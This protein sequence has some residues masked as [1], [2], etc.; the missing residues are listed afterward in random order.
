MGR[1]SRW[2]FLLFAMALTSAWLTASPA[3]AT[4]PG[5]NG[6]IAFTGD[7]NGVAHIFTINPDGS[8][9]TDLGIGSDPAWSADG[10]RIVFQRAGHVYVMSAT[11][12]N[13]TNL[14]R[15]RTGDQQPTW[16][17][18]GRRIAFIHKGHVWVML[19]DGSNAH[20]IESNVVKDYRPT[21]STATESSYGR[22]II[23][24]ARCCWHGLGTGGSFG[25][26][27]GMDPSGAHH[28]DLFGF[29]L[30]SQARGPCGVGFRHPDW[31]PGG[32]GWFAFTQN[33]NGGAEIG[34]GAIDGPDRVFSGQ[35]QGVDGRTRNGDPNYSPDSSQV[36]YV[37]PWCGKAFPTTSVIHILTTPCPPSECVDRILT[38]GWAPAWQ[39]IPAS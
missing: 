17:P 18:N 10:T 19:A 30:Q 11:G 24:V 15:R 9:R 32:S 29:G 34:Y 22:P 14:S 39:P 7:V 36:A 20:A 2:V 33:F 13:V 5:A 21:W 8:G 3:A 35:A 1:L 16:S 6:L 37:S 4:F 26:I 27:V 23:A 38:S 25:M 12:E 31:W 28:Y